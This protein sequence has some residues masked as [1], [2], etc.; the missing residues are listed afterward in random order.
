MTSSPRSRRA[1]KILLILLAVPLFGAVSATLWIKRVADRRWADAQERIRQLA[2]NFPAADALPSSSMTE[3]SKE[4]QIHFVAAIRE[5]V[6]RNGR[7]KEARGLLRARQRGEALDA[8]LDDA[9]DFLDRLH[10]AARHCAAAPSDFPP[11][12]RGEWDWDTLA[13]IMNCSV[14]RARRLR[15]RKAPF[16]SVETLLDSLQL[17]R[18]WAASGKGAN[19]TDALFSLTDALDELRD[20][21][22]REMLSQDELLK[23]DRELESLEGA[24]KSPLGFLEPALARWAEEMLALDLTDSQRMDEAPYRWRYFLPQHLM[25]A[26]AF[27]FADRHVHRLIADEG[28][29]YLELPRHLDQ[30]K[31]EMKGS[32]NPIIC[33]DMSFLRYWLGWIALER[34]AE[35]RLLRV[36]TRYRGTGEIL[37]LEDPYGTVLHHSQ[38]ESRINFWSVGSDGRDDG[39]DAASDGRWSDIPEPGVPYHRPGKD[40]VIEVE[41]RRSPRD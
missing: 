37:L 40:L 18:F 21:L 15:E 36:A 38:T 25:K 2:E 16:E 28:K 34:K 11:G 3:A 19:R 20:V 1:W 24:M 14:L 31:E 26:E 33:S 12:W 29:A 8:V 9:A 4:L 6:R 17:A 41:R 7:A 10:L 22:G 27:E 35:L 5:A 30:L 13:F 23:M 39:G 32:K